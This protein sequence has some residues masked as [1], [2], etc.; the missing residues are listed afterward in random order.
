MTRRKIRTILWIL[1]G[2]V[3]SLAAIAV[4]MTG[5]AGQVLVT[6]AEGISLAA[7]NVMHC[8]QDGDW[9][10]LTSAVSG[11]PE[12]SFQTGE[13]N[14]AEDLIW[15]AYRQS[16]QWSCKDG[17]E[18]QGGQVIQQVTVNCLN[19]SELTKQLREA[20]RQTEDNTASDHGLK[21]AAEEVLHRDMPM[22]QKEIRMCFVR[23]DGQWKLVPD[24]A[25][26]ALLSGF[27]AG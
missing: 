21:A 3:L 2:L 12:L 5:L 19:I 15:D 7:D 27:T 25:L 11:A 24:S 13:E 26:L 23:T 4:V 6:D 1:A 22:V 17:Y 14:T 9:E 8:I 18:V 10:E 16:L 20:M